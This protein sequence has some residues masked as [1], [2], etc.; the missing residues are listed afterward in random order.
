MY[1]S[2]VDCRVDTGTHICIMFQINMVIE[3]TFVSTCWRW[4]IAFDELMKWG[5]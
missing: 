4:G 1:V 3:L 5:K 2:A